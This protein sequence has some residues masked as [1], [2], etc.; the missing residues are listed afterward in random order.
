MLKL[1]NSAVS[2]TLLSALY[3]CPPLHAQR[4]TS[5]VTM[6]MVLSGK[7][8]PQTLRVKDL[9]S[10]YRRFRFTSA[11]VLFATQRGAT[12]DLS[13]FFTKGQS[14]TFGGNEY[15]IAYRPEVERNPN[16]DNHGQMNLM[17]TKLRPADKLLL[18]LLSTQGFYGSSLTDIRPFD[19]ELD[20]ETQADRNQ[21]VQ[22]VLRQLGAGILNWKHNRGQ[23]RLPQWGKRVN[24]ALRRQCYPIV[25]DKRLWEHPSTNEAFGLNAALA[26]QR[27]PDITNRATLYMVYEFTP[28]AD[29]TRAVL[30]ADGHVERVDAARWTRLQKTPIQTK[31]KTA[32]KAAKTRSSNTD[33]VV[34]P[35][36]VQR[37]R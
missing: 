7:S 15:L 6:E 14:V 21:A 10:T 23:E 36:R 24:D 32:A 37:R 22:Q 2:L 27:L 16:M 33:V 34:N 17:L 1:S 28:A 35:P 4:A 13:I 31:P 30:F 19:P 18:S 25:H 29:G 9:D 12:R 11:D 3:F 20:M 5:A 26:N 8:I